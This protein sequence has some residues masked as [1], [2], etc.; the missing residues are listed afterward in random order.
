MPTAFSACA[1]P[2][3][4]LGDDVICVKFQLLAN[5]LKSSFMKHVALSVIKVMGTAVSEKM[6]LKAVITEFAGSEGNQ[7]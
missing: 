4:Y 2:L 1:L 6:V 5:S 7:Y 3:G